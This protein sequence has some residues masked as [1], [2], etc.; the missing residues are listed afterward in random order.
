MGVIKSDNYF[1]FRVSRLMNGLPRKTK[2]T[3]IR[4]YKS[5]SEDLLSVNNPS[6]NHRVVYGAVYI[7]TQMK[8]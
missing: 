7:I 4:Y 3:L 5:L 6:N 2:H 8:T 1:L